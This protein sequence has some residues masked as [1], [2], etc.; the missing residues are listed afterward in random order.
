MKSDVTENTYNLQNTCNMHITSINDYSINREG[1]YNT[2]NNYNTHNTYTNANRKC[3]V[4]IT[5]I[6]FTTRVTCVTLKTKNKRGK[7]LSIQTSLAYMKGVWHI[8]RI[9]CI[10]LITLRTKIITGKKVGLITRLTCTTH[11]TCIS[12]GTMLQY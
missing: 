4:L 7:W 8:T 6:T 5:R 12:L 11:V 10:K 2:Y 9:T 3:A 1:A